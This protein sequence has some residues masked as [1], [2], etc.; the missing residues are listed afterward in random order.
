MSA[1]FEQDSVTRSRAQKPTPRGTAVIDP[2]ARGSDAVT[3]GA[4][5]RALTAAGADVCAEW[6]HTEHGATSAADIRTTVTALIENVRQALSGDSPPSATFP[7]FVPVRRALEL[8][9]RA[10]LERAEAPDVMAGGEHSV[11]EIIKAMERVQHAIDQDAAHRFAA[12]LSGQDAQQL[13]VEMAHDM[14]SPL[15]SILI[16][17]ERLRYGSGGT[18][19]PIQERQL[20]LVYSA[21][22]GLSALAGDVIELAR[23]GTT[24]MDQPPMPFLV[25]DVLQSIMDILRPMAEE[26]RLV[27]RCTGPEADLRVGYQAALNRVLLNLATNAIKFTNAGSV[28][29]TCKQ[30]DR[31][32]VEFSV[33]DT[34]RGIPPHVMSNLFE[35]FR[36]RQITGD[37]AFSSA[38]LGLSICK[39]LIVAMGGELGVETELE[40]GTRFHFVLDLPQGSRL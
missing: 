10:F 11:L 28:D 31:S 4:V 30:L 39:K 37:Y 15:G 3:A 38:G 19:T 32:H 16:L 25:S 9:R 14:R 17:A 18:L 8:L 29:I 5:W 40:K 1:R 24:L 35:A 2:D 22:F 21:A 27:V 13:V 6:L 20:G 12:R 36:Q 23:G 26:K 34:G 7:P 33:K